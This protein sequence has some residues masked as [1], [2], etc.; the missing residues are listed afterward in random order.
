MTTHLRFL[1]RTVLYQCSTRIHN[2][3][4]AVG[5]GIAFVAEAGGLVRAVDVEVRKWTQGKP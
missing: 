4:A 1:G 5:N 2:L 3:L